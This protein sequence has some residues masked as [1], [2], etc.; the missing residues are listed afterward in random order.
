MYSSLPHTPI[1]G[2]TV[3][4]SSNFSKKTSAGFCVKCP[5]LNVQRLSA[6]SV[7]GPV[8]GPGNVTVNTPTKFHLP[9]P[10]ILITSL[11]HES[12][13]N[14]CGNSLTVEIAFV[15]WAGE[16]RDLHV[17][18]QGKAPC[19]FTCNPVHCPE[20]NLFRKVWGSPGFPPSP[21]GLGAPP[22]QEVYLFFF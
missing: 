14:L 12:Q 17:Y 21:S 8:L 15:V 9:G 22:G 18:F 6:H 20:A 3:V 2:P 7:P 11:W 5:G 1:R 16:F 13:P 4:K 10:Y 19:C